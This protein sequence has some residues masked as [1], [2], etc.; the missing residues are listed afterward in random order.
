[1][2]DNFRIDQYPGKKAGQE[3]IRIDRLQV[4]EALVPF[5]AR[6]ILEIGPYFRVVIDHDRI[7]AEFLPKGE[8]FD[9]IFRRFKEYGIVRSI[10]PAL[11]DKAECYARF[12]AAGLS[13]QQTA[14]FV[15]G[16]SR[17]MKAVEMKA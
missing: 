15:S 12:S 9:F 11:A 7:K 2:R 13:R 4:Q 10:V 8:G 6:R 14:A 17:G 16:K 1:M 5:S 3:P